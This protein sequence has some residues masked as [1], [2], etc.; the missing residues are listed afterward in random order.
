MSHKAVIKKR[1]RE[2]GCIDNLWC[3][4]NRVT[5]RLGAAIFVLKEE[6]WEFDD[7]RSGFIPGTKNWRY[8]LK[9]APKPKQEFIPGVGRL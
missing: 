3:I 9:S 7:A 6:G 5:T 1:L 4:E 8:V 2:N